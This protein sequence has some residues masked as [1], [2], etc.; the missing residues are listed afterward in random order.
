M[1][2]EVYLTILG[3]FLSALTGAGLFFLQRYKEKRDEQQDVL[4]KI[5]QLMS[6]PRIFGHD[7][8]AIFEN[9]QR[10]NDIR[11]LSFLIKDKKLGSEIYLYTRPNPTIKPEVTQKKILKRLNKKMFQELIQPEPKEPNLSGDK[12]HD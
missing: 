3:G 1:P 10:L 5:Y 12:K 8:E 6:T 9:K 4:F 2:K 11:I 7:I